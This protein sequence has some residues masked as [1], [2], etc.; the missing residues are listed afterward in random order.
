MLEKRTK[1]H[2]PVLEKRTKKAEMTLEKQT[3]TKLLLRFEGRCAKLLSTIN[4]EVLTMLR[5]KIE[6]KIRKFYESDKKAL[7]P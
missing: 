7:L 1:Q 5:R 2:E 3:D 4:L 6:E